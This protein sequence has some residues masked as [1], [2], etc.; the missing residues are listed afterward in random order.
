M[1]RWLNLLLGLVLGLLALEFGVRLTT[2]E[3]EADGNYWGRGAFV[4]DADA[5][6]RH[7]PSTAATFGRMGAFGPITVSTNAD[8]YRDPRPLA[9]TPESGPQ[10]MIVGS[11]M[12]FGLG[13]E[14][15][16][17]L[18]TRQ[19]E[20]RLRERPELPEDLEV[21]NVSQTGY[22][23]RE[24]ELLVRR[25]TPTVAPQ[26]V[27]LVL[28][29]PSD[30]VTRMGDGAVLDVLNGYRLPADRP[31]AGGLVDLLRTRSVAGM[32]IARSPLLKPAAYVD[33]QLLAR[34]L[35]GDE[36]LRPE[37]AGNPH[38]Q[39]TRQDVLRHVLEI[40]RYLDRRGIAF[41]VMIVYRPWLRSRWLSKSLA[42]APFEVIG[43]DTPQ[44]WLH[45]SDGHW[46][47][48]GHDAAAALVAP[49]IPAAPFV[50]DPP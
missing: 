10:L 16:E 40:H 30:R 39:G 20:R 37:S 17:A 21:R 23:A 14:Q 49:R 8:G 45:G 22:L 36:E 4:E 3:H 2:Y 19:L 26:M 28:T 38:A 34:L 41:G 15:D 12:M 25:E 50:Q 42:G 6:Y 5:G 47:V 33:D 35:R 1:L 13:V 18:F 44:E 27:L 29:A 32:R 7:A 48:A 11:S 43:V 9:P 24:L 46:T 31:L